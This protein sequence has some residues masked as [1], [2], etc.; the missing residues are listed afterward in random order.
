MAEFGPPPQ[1]TREDFI[2]L[3]QRNLE[4]HWIE[5]LLADPSSSSV[6]EGLIAVMLRIQDSIDENIGIGS[7]ILTAPGSSPAA[8]TVRLERPSGAEVVIDTTFRFL[9]QRG[10]IWVPSASFTIP[11]SGGAQSVDIPI[12]TVRRGYYLNSFEP[13]TYRILDVLPDPNLI[14]VAGIDPAEGGKTAFLDQHGNER[15]LYRQ[16]SEDDQIYRNRIRFI[17]DAVSPTAIAEA[18]IQILDPYPATRPIVDLIIQYGL[19]LLR[20]PF[21]SPEQL[22]QSNLYGSPAPFCDDAFCDD[23]SGPYLELLG[24]SC[25]WFDVYLP[26][27]QDPDEARLFIDDGFFDTDGY[28]DGPP[29]PNI[30]GPIAALADELDRRRGMCIRFKIILGEEAILSRTPPLF[31]LTQIGDWVDQDGSVLDSDIVDALAQMDANA[32]YV[33]SATGTG[34]GVP[35]AV[36]DLLFSMP[37]IP[38]PVSID[39]V[40]IVAWAKAEDVAAGT[41][42]ELQFL[43]RPVGAGSAVRVGAP[44]II[45]HD[46]YRRIDYIVEENPVTALPW[47]LADIAGAVQ[48]GIANAAAIGATEELRVSSLSLEIVVNYG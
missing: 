47:T 5:G 39:D 9:D 44:V 38:A 37:T 34:P 41:D 31:S 12:Q 14:A 40:R 32:T 22:S 24:E 1:L 48:F 25:A 30:T 21:Q 42:P 17:E 7:F 20:E 23:P 18:I 26:T 6:F 10:A 46:D 27:P 13:L 28:F 3:L 8:S 19:R 45:D 43:I 35:I 4:P 11:A 36:G 15:R 2:D 33:A 29:G 16:E